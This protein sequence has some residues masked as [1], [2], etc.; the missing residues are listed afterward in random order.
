MT[1]T[2][3]TGEMIIEKFQDIQDDTGKMT[4]FGWRC[5]I[6]GEIFDPVI[7]TN[8]KLHPPPLVG[9]NRKLIIASKR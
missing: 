8:R 2:R 6:C 5:L 1:C 3:C 4:F 9:K 7:H